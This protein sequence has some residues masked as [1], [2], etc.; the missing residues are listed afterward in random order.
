MGHTGSRV[1]RVERIGPPTLSTLMSDLHSLRGPGIPPTLDSHTP[2][3]YKQSLAS[4]YLF[5]K[6]ECS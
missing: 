4:I 1:H 6:W 3:A 5:I 2:S